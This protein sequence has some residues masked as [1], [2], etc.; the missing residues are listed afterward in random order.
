MD[1]AGV[2][3]GVQADDLHR[4]GHRLGYRQVVARA[5]GGDGLLET[6]GVDEH[7]GYRAV[8]IRAQ[9]QGQF[10]VHQHYVLAGLGQGEAAVL[11][12]RP[13]GAAEVHVVAAFDQA[14]AFFGGQCAHG[15][16]AL[17]ALRQDRRLAVADDDHPGLAAGD[18]VDSLLQVVEEGGA[19]ACDAAGHADAAEHVGID[20]IGGHAVEAQRQ[21]LGRDPVALQAGLHQ[22]AET[23]VVELA[24]DAAGE[25]RDL[26]GLDVVDDGLPVDAGGADRVGRGDHRHLQAARVEARVVQL[27][28]FETGG[29]LASGLHRQ[30]TVA[31]DLELAALVDAHQYLAILRGSDRPVGR[32][33]LGQL[34]GRGLE[35]QRLA[36]G[37]GQLEDLVPVDCIRVEVLRFDASHQG[38]GEDAFGVAPLDVLRGQRRAV[39]GQVAAAFGLDQFHHD[40]QAG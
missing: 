35:G 12:E 24:H 29:Q 27:A 22:A 23:V 26:V 16:V 4:A 2:A 17:N 10:V 40:R 39:F 1:E 38:R 32:Q 30:R 9:A 6:V 21:L 7:V 33:R 11:A 28:R 20:E 19:G 8:D 14:Q 15:A 13:A 31:V 34:L 3:H 5:G 36:F 25:H 37:R 18:D